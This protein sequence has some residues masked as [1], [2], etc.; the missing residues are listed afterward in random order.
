M[1]YFIRQFKISK[2]QFTAINESI[3]RGENINPTDMHET[4]YV[5]TV[6]DLAFSD[7]EIK[8][9]YYETDDLDI[10]RSHLCGKTVWVAAERLYSWDDM[11]YLSRKHDL[12]FYSSSWEELYMKPYRE[13]Y[14]KRLATPGVSEELRNEYQKILTQMLYIRRVRD[15]LSD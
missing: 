4:K 1:Y 11:V 3:K 5:R 14:E 13:Y 15:P 8:Y 9:L 7:E 10:I 12:E 2:E 6:E